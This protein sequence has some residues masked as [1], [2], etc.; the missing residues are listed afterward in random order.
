[1]GDEAFVDTLR[2]AM[3]A[4]RRAGSR[5]RSPEEAGPSGS[6]SSTLASDITSTSTTSASFPHTHHFISEAERAEIS[7][8]ILLSSIERV[9]NALHDLQTNFTFP[10]HL[11]YHLPSNFSHLNPVDEE[12]A[13]SIATYLPTTSRNSIVFNFVRELRGLLRQLDHL[14]SKKDPEAESM[15]KKVVAALNEALDDVESRIEEGVG[16]WMSLQAVEVDVV[17]S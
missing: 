13:G 4:S 16:K 11:D 12:N 9:E 3:A 7:H 14:D 2:E 17:G 8:A 1:M 6:S 5:I 10:T 15:K